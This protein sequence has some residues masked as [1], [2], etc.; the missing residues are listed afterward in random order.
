MDFLIALGQDVVI[1]V[2]PTAD[3]VRMYP[4]W[5]VLAL[6]KWAI[7]H[8]DPTHPKSRNATIA[9]FIQLIHMVHRVFDAAP[10]PRGPGALLLLL[11][12]MAF[13]Q[14]W[15]QDHLAASDFGRQIVL[16]EELPP[17]TCN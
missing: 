11:K 7:L 12:N 2:R 1:T 17:D 6:L 8:S 14:L 15:L 9:D 13:Q 3:K 16:F 4:A 5:F 10:V